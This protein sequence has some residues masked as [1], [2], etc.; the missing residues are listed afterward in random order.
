MIGSYILYY[1]SLRVARLPLLG[2]SGC[3]ALGTATEADIFPVR[4][5]SLV[6]AVP[7]VE[8]GSRLGRVEVTMV[9]VE[10]HGVSLVSDLSII[11]RNMLVYTIYC[12]DL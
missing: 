6:T 4:T 10:P 11:P 7:A 1:A 2:R 8:L 3:A 12:A 5:L 9:N